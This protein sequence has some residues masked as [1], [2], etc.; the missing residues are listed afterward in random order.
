[1]SNYG[2]LNVEGTITTYN[3]LTGLQLVSTTNNG[4]APIVVTSSTLVSNLNA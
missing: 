3:N 4:T 2:I 1:M